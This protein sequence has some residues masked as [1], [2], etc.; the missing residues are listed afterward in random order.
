MFKAN[1]IGGKPVLTRDGGEKIASVK[2]LIVSPDRTRVIGLLLD[3]GGL[4]TENR[5]VPIDSLVSAGEDAVII[6]DHSAIYP[7]SRYP[8]AA[9]SLNV[10][11]RLVGKRAVTDQ[12]EAQGKIT[13]VVFEERSGAIVG[14]DL[15]GLRVEGAEYGPVF[16]PINEIISIGPDVII[17]RADALPRL[18]GYN[19]NMSNMTNIPAPSM[20]M[21]EPERYVETDANSQATSPPPVIVETR[22]EPVTSVNPHV[23]LPDR[24]ES[25]SNIHD[26]D[27]EV[28]TPPQGTRNTAEL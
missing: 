26:A 17:V 5:V 10:K 12:G 6:T 25:Y 11:D 16:L 23:G 9:E 18:L 4:F 8:D 27:T 14:F 2:E 7:V 21:A 24:I 20:S 15:S 28:V 22:S 13:D 3:G 19:S 1:Y